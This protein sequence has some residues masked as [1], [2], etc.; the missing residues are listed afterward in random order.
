MERILGLDLGEARVGVA[1]SDPLRII[2]SPYKIIESKKENVEE[3]LFKIIEKYNIKKIVYGLP[4]SLSGEK[5][6]QAEAVNEMIKSLKKIFTKITFVPYDERFTSKIAKD[7]L[8]S[9]GKKNIGK[10][11]DSLAASILLQNYL[12]M[13]KK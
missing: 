10:S 12:D 5:G 9:K 3:E 4:I 2:A 1:I 11:L 7:V 8:K 13:N 6:R